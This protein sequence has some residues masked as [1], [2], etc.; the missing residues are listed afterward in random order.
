MY[1]IMFNISYF[2]HCLSGVLLLLFSMT[3]LLDSFVTSVTPFLSPA[4][5]PTPAAALS[6]PPSDPCRFKNENQL[7]QSKPVLCN[8][9]KPITSG[10]YHKL[11]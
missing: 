10:K 11:V 3:A 2:S 1:A 9:A 6:L 7:D 5:A 8:M 4:V